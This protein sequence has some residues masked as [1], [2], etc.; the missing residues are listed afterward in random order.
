MTRAMLEASSVAVVGA[1]VR[2]G[3]LGNQMLVELERGGFGGRLYPVNPKY[4]EIRGVRC[5][6]GIADVPEPV[7]VA[8]LGVANSRQQEQAE[9][10]AAARA[11][12]LVIFASLY[13]GEQDEVPLKDRVAAVASEAGMGVCGGN[14]MG[15]LNVEKRV[16]ATGFSMPSLEPGP[17]CFISHSG[18]A[19]AAFAFNHRKLAFNL[20]ASPGQELTTTAADYVDYALQLEST[21]AIGLF[22][23]EIKDPT[24]F[25]R[26]LDVAAQRDIPVVALK[27]G[28][29]PLSQDLVYVHSRA[30]AGDDEVYDALFER[31]GVLRVRTL[32]EMADTLELFTSQRRA[33]RGGLAAM[34]DSGGERALFVDLAADAGVRLAELAPETTD[35]LEATLDPGLAAT[36]PVDAWGS[37]LGQE[38][39]FIDCGRALVADGD[40]AALA[41]VIDVTTEDVPDEG[42]V[43]VAKETFG[44]S[45]KPFAVVSNLSAAIDP[46]DAGALRAAGIPVLE[47]VATGLSA[48]RHLFRYRDARARRMLAESPG[49]ASTEQSRWRARLSSGVPLAPNEVTQLLSTYG[50]VVDAAEETAS[51]PVEPPET[52]LGFV[53]DERF[54][55]LITVG[56]GRSAER[57]RDRVAIPPLDAERAAALLEHIAVGEFGSART[58][59]MFEALAGLAE[60]A[61][62]LGSSVRSVAL[63]Q[64]AW[65]A[66]DLVVRQVGIE[67]D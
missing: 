40:T 50:I 55:P 18:S 26:A 53:R 9:A 43:R 32:A 14:C 19:F 3:T 45:D 41:F 15:F 2:V 46:R 1:S 29:T 54:G 35:R 58:G 12:S 4:G 28:R 44:A 31:H 6:P 56:R 42:H 17:I 30:D 65:R 47:D 52:W 16:C 23:E 61:E 48:F 33:P 7:D 36:N 13:D 37:G 27:V 67:L 8:I 10:A 25:V 57:T 49:R 59:S 66:D 24:T 62:H 63:E 51:E 38:D 60:M 21:R 39:I 22:L 64:L 34:H 5:Y 11:R 20:L